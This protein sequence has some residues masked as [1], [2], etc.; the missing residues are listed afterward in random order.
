MVG[1]GKKREK[2]KSLMEILRSDVSLATVKDLFTYEIPL[3]YS[4]AMVEKARAAIQDEKLSEEELHQ[5]VAE[6]E[7]QSDLISRV[8]TDRGVI[9][10]EDLSRIAEEKEKSGLPFLQVLVSLKIVS[11]DQMSDLAQDLRRAI[12][13]EEAGT[14]LEDCLIRKNLVKEEAL[15][16]AKELART[17]R[18]SL[19][20]ALL[21]ADAVSFEQLG[22]VMADEFGIKPISVEKEKIDRSVVN[23]VPDNIM[24]D[25]Q[26]VPVRREGKKLVLAMANPLDVKAL[27][28]VR[29]VTG[30]DPIPRFAHPDAVEKAHKHFILEIT[31]GGRTGSTGA[32]TK[33][34][35]ELV[36]SEST[37]KLVNNIIEGAVNSR[38]TDIHL[39]PQEDNLRVRYRVDGMLYDL[40]R[41]PGDQAPAT[42][43]RIKVLAHMDITERRRPQDGHVTVKTGRREIN[44]RASTL[45]THLGEKIVLRVIQDSSI[46]RGLPQLGLSHDEITLIK[47]MIARPHGMFLVTGPMGSGKTTTLYAAL[48]EVNTPN[49]NIVTIEDPIE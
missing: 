21:R 33:Q 8:L 31:T 42:V 47:E 23:L 35:E 16:K 4:G 43:S 14:R 28:K 3:P 34:L 18:I 2:K 10:E 5:L 26:L 38:A 24:K 6:F 39:E 44:L 41:I 25:F 40:M 48:G 45:P 12:E 46:V 29:M 32:S 27:D 37:V 49:R 20:Q 9:K 22:K 15:R 19:E 30:L 13:A 11:P 7:R 36:S 17:E 1:T